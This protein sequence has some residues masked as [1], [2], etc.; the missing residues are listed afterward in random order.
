VSN[1]IDAVLELSGPAAYLAIAALAYAETAVLAGLILPGEASVMLGGLLAER[2]NLSLPAIIA[3]CIV[4]AIAGDVTGYWVGQR[5]LRALLRV[6][7][8]RG[9]VGS[10]LDKSKDFLDRRGA[11][12]LFFAR[13]ASIV[14]TLA[15]PV[16]G[17]SK[18]PFATFIVGA[19]AGAATWVTAFVLLGYF[20]GASFD[21]IEQIAGR[22]SL[23]ILIVVAVIVVARWLTRAVIKRKEYVVERWRRISEGRP[24]QWLVGRYGRELRWLGRRVDP[25]LDRGLRLTVALLALGAAALVAGILIE[26]VIGRE[27]SA[28]WDRPV[29]RWISEHR[30]HEAASLA[31]AVTVPFELPLVIVTI[32]VVAGV[33]VWRSGRHSGVRALT[34]VSGAVGL[35]VVLQVLLA[36]RTDPHEF[37]AEATAAAAAITVALSSVVGSQMR[38]VAGVRT[39]GAGAAVT[40]ILGIAGLVSA[41]STFTGVMAGSAIGALWAAAV[42]V[43]RVGARRPR[44]DTDR[45]RT[46]RRRPSQTGRRNRDSGARRRPRTRQTSDR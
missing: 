24:V 32:A 23:V 22:A 17:M 26:D 4:A 5:W 12:A 30:T 33:L 39:A 6:E 28:L 38:W 37:P 11:S 20:A 40:M 42:E 14:R 7:W 43:A 46:S 27:E 10:Q 35:C 9:I 29:A 34:S 15:P 21:A 36:D 2:G 19:A 13:W 25:Q 31:E 3:V 41:T 44:S 8:F 1:V 45:P 18:G 16:A